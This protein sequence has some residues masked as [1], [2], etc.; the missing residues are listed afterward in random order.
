MSLTM[1]LGS[2]GNALRE[3]GQPEKRVKIESPILNADE[4]NTVANTEGISLQTLST[5]YPL[6]KAVSDPLNNAASDC[7]IDS[8]FWLLSGH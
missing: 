8:C 1:F 3:D 4:L 5:L 2:R 7:S 6:T